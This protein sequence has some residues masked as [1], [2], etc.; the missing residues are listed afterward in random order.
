MTPIVAAEPTAYAKNIVTVASGK[1]GVGKTWLAITLAHALA[2]S[3]RRILLFDGDLG[4]AN[5][6]VQLGLAPRQNLGAVVVGEVSLCDVVSRYEKGGFDI[7]AGRSGS[8]DLASLGPGRP[9]RLRD[10]LVDLAVEYDNVITDLGAGVD[11][12]V[13]ALTFGR[14]PCLVVTSDEPTAL[15]DAYAFI[16][17]TSIDQP[18]SDLRVVVNAAKSLGQGQ[19][20]YETIAKVCKNFLKISPPLAGIVRHDPRI[21]DAIRHQTGLLTRYPSCDAASD[22]LQLAAGLVD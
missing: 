12:E 17:L 3:G 5:V 8:G 22:V 20:T 16:K 11:L 9:H 15:T 19:L 1:G 21:P 6:D 10:Q 13:R 4:L 2:Q 7:I 14:G 18:R